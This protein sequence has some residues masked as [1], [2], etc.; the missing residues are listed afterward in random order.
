MIVACSVAPTSTQPEITANTL[1]RSAVAVGS[2]QPDSYWAN[3]FPFSIK[4]T[5]ASLAG[6]YRLAVRLASADE[7]EAA[8]IQSSAATIVRNLSTN[9]INV[10]MSFH[11]DTNLF[12]KATDWAEGLGEGSTLLDKAKAARLQPN[13]AYKL[14]AVKLT[15]DDTVHPLSSFTTDAEL[16]PADLDTLGITGQAFFNF[17]LDFTDFPGASGHSFTIRQN[18]PFLFLVGIVNPA[19]AFEYEINST[20]FTTCDSTMNDCF[21]ISSSVHSFYFQTLASPSD[22]RILPFI[23][24]GRSVSDTLVNNGRLTH[25]IREG[26]RVYRFNTVVEN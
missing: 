17:P 13:T 15:G 9:S 11:M 23:A 24:I 8:E 20:A 3:I 25:I 16:T 18:E 2:L 7:P 10:L 26:E 19:T 4:V 14:Y 1:A 22:T 6:E 5:D 12:D 21:P